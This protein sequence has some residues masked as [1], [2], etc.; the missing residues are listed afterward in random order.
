MEALLG[1]AIGGAVIVFL[2]AEG[3]RSRG[4]L[5]GFIEKRDLALRP[6]TIRC[7]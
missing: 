3:R 2:E 6:G 4:R 1:G 7:S 5:D